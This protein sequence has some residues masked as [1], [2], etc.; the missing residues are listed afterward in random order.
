MYLPKKYS[1]FVFYTGCSTGR[2]KDAQLCVYV[3]DEKVVDLWGSPS[4]AYTAETLTTV[5]SRHQCNVNNVK[6]IYQ[7]CQQC[8]IHISTVSTISTSTVSTMWTMWTMSNTKCQ[9]C[10]ASAS[11]K[12][13][14]WTCFSL[15]LIL[16]QRAWQPLPLQ[17]SMTKG[18][19][20]TRQGKKWTLIILLGQD[21]WL[22]ARVWAEGKG[23]DN[24]GRSDE[25][26]GDTS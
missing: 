6:Y 20:I 21:L 13:N 1:L 2:E 5:F 8:Q 11:L 24:G 3:G 15:I 7:L 22:L 18:C 19:W 9:E 12:T 10:T 25:T 23:E 4:E 26:W 16:A 14:F 17:P